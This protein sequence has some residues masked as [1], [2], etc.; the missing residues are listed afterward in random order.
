MKYQISANELEYTVATFENGKEVAWNYFP[1][2]QAARKYIYRV[3]H[4]G[5]VEAY[6]AKGRLIVRETK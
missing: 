2:L 1:T 6:D 4:V 3:T 5:N